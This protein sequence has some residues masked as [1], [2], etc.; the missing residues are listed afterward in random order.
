MSLTITIHPEHEL[1]VRGKDLNV[2]IVVNATEEKK[3]RGIH[4]KFSGYERTEATYTVTTTDHKGRTKPR[5][6]RRSS[7]TPSS[8]KSFHCRA[9]PR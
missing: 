5:R 7:T 4:A 6:E 9:P 3:I 8:S 2:R 1:L